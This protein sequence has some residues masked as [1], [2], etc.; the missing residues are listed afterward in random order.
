MS[1][2]DLL[3][4][5]TDGVT[6]AVNERGE[7]F[8]DARVLA[9]AERQAEISP[10]GLRDGLLREVEEFSGGRPNP[11]DLALLAVRFTGGGR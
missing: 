7:S 9:W 2:G 8:G 5:Y 1:R 4:L 6:E 3:L 11:D 10:T